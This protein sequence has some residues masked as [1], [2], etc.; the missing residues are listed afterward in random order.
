M[1]TTKLIEQ[2]KPTPLPAP[3]RSRMQGRVDAVDA[4]RVLGWAYHTERPNERL[5]VEALVGGEVIARGAADQARIDLRR[6][7][8]GDGAHAFSLELP[9]EM[10]GKLAAIEIR[11][12]AEDGEVLVLRIPT[13]DERAAE[14]AVAAPVARVMERLDF[15]VAAQRQLQ[16][17]QRDT[18]TA[19]KTITERLDGLC[20]EGGTIETAVGDVSRNQGELL[21]RVQSMEVFLARFD[22]TLAGFDAR[23]KDLEKVGGQDV[24]PVVVLLSTLAGIVCGALLTLFVA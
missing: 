13:N 14:A 23:L 5:A 19:L 8:I 24:K 20:A 7:G 10:D 1:K 4:G 2:D 16:F 9:P 12:L 21:E 17:G 15:L 22:S 18:G 3:R 11:A 6:N